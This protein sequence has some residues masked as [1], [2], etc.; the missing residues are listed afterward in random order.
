MNKQQ[1]FKEI[2]ETSFNINKMKKSDKNHN[3][4]ATFTFKN[5]TFTLIGSTLRGERSQQNLYKFYLAATD[6]SLAQWV[7]RQIKKS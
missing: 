3:S 5:P 2:V 7:R 4:K 6:I 1:I